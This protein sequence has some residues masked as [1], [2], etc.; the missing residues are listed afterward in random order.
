MDKI[1]EM[2]QHLVQYYAKYSRWIDMGIRFVLAILTFTFIGS[3]IGFKVALT[4]PII[5]VVL[6]L[7]CA[8][9]PMIMTAVFAAERKMIRLVLLVP[10]RST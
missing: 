1:Y 6:S 8:L 5:T 7:V 3:H 9:L 10:I 2:K 4:N